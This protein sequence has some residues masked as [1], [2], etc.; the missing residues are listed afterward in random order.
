MGLSRWRW[1][2][3]EWVQLGEGLGV[4][5]CELLVCLGCKVGESMLWKLGWQSQLVESLDYHA[6]GF[7]FYPEGSEGPWKA[8]KQQRAMI[9]L[10]FRTMALSSGRRW[11]RAR[12]WGSGDQEGP[13]DV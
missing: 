9:T 8:F 6:K 7:G 1:E 2:R 3:E 10:I 11:T 12:V 5:S 13:T 4:G